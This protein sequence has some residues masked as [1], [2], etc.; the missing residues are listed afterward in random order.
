[1]KTGVFNSKRL[2]DIVNGFLWTVHLNCKTKPEKR[3][4]KLHIIMGNSGQAGLF[5]ELIVKHGL[6]LNP[7]QIEN[8]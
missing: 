3:D 5:Y 6:I 4:R 8:Q 1:M 2:I 7:D